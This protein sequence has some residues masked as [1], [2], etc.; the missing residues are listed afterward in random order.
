[1]FALLNLGSQSVGRWPRLAILIILLEVVDLK[2]ATLSKFRYL[3]P[4]GVCGTVT[5]GVVE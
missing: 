1:M 2:P 3:H 4:C 5:W